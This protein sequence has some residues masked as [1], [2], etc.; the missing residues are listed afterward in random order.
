M[1]NRKPNSFVDAL[2]RGRSLVEAMAE[3]MTRSGLCLETYHEQSCE[4]TIDSGYQAQADGSQY[5]N[6]LRFAIHGLGHNPPGP[7]LSCHVS[8]RIHGSDGICSIEISCMIYP[9]IQSWQLEQAHFPAAIRSPR[10]KQIKREADSWN[11]AAR[12]VG[13]MPELLEA[14]FTK[15]RMEDPDLAQDPFAGVFFVSAF[16]LPGSFPPLPIRPLVSQAALRF[17]YAPSIR[18]FLPSRIFL[19]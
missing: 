13:L 6:H 11:Q 4:T 19:K 1:T 16:S 7:H 14:I 18:H 8:A 9:A 10:M 2:G 12:P 3:L 17:V 5:R 15:H